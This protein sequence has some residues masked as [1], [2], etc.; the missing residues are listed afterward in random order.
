M[1]NLSS[2]LEGDGISEFIEA[3]QK[4][5]DETMMEQMLGE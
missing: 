2:V 5:Y 1:R 4:N 3:L